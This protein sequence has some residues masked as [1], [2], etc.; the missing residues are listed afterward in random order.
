[1]DECFRCLYRCCFG[2]AGGAFFQNFHCHRDTLE[3]PASLTERGVLGLLLLLS[4]SSSISLRSRRSWG[5]SLNA[6]FGED[7]KFIAHAWSL[8][9]L[10]DSSNGAIQYI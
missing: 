9:S 3:A 4:I 8:E 5:N 1:V 10:G 7:G 2:D 6:C